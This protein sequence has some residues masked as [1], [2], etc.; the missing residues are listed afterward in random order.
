[1]LPVVTTQSTWWP[2]GKLPM[3]KTTTTHTGSSIFP[4]SGPGVPEI[5]QD[6]VWT[7][8]LWFWPIYNQ[9]PLWRSVI[10][11]YITYDTAIT[12][13]ES[14]LDIIITTD[15]H[16]SPSRA[17]YGA[18][19]VRILEK[20][21]HVITAPPCIMTVIPWNA[22]DGNKAEF[23]YLYLYC[24]RHMR[25]VFFFYVPST[26]KQYESNG[27]VHWGLAQP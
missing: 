25:I 17:S 2:L 21:D 8:C 27:F 20:I 14:E 5:I 4:F 12:V 24:K 9:V 13:A 19:I 10:Y 1:M 23:D 11:R 6:L 18:S 3:P 26:G 7:G 16:S 22:A 15:T